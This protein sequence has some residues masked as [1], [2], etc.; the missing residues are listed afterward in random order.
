MLG[1]L[2]NCWD[3]GLPTTF[4]ASAVTENDQRWAM[5]RP[6]YSD[7]YAYIKFETGAHSTVFQFETLALS[8]HNTGKKYNSRGVEGGL[9]FTMCKKLVQVQ[10]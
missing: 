2:L 9:S 8:A 5:W 10:Y 6:N 4:K 7:G 1:N 3:Q